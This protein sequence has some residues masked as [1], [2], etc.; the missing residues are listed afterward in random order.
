[1]VDEF[2]FEIGRMAR[3]PKRSLIAQEIQARWLELSAVAD[4]LSGTQR[5]AA[6]ARR[7]DMLEALRVLLLTGH[8]A[9]AWATERVSRSLTD[10]DDD[11]R[12][13]GAYYAVT[14]GLAARALET[15]EEILCLLENGLARG[16]RGRLRTLEEIFVVAGVIAYHGDPAGDHPSLPMRYIEH[17]DVFAR[18][19]ADELIA[20]GSLPDNHAL[21]AETLAQLERRRTELVEKYGKEYQRLWGWASELFPPKTQ[22]NL[23]V[24]AETLNVELRGFYSLSSRHVHASSEGWH[25]AREDDGEEGDNAGFVGTFAAG[26]L[27]LTLQAVIP[28]RVVVDDEVA[29]RTGEAWSDALVW[30]SLVARSQEPPTGGGD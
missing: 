26:Y 20:T 18:G 25:E 13:F 6:I 23:G 16:A 21:D 12:A 19:L 17:R 27:V 1:M 28:T 15:F 22:I 29:D 10:S 24:L 14:S 5:A 8:E 2:D 11:D 3:S 30:L 7:Q 9:L 4:K